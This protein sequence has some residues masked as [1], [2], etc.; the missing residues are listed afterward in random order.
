MRNYYLDTNNMKMCKFKT[1]GVEIVKKLL[2][3]GNDL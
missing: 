3:P 2:A 1:D